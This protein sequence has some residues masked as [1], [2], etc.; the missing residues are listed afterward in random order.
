MRVFCGT[1]A[2]MCCVEAGED[3]A[4]AVHRVHQGMCVWLHPRTLMHMCAA[5]H[6]VAPFEVLG[7]CSAAWRKTQDTS[8]MQC[9]RCAGGTLGANGNEHGAHPGP[10]TMCGTN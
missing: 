8:V 7:L 2:R 3:A 5:S 6:H 9:A 4:R 10:Q 1:G